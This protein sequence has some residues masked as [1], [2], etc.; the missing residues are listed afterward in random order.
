VP[1]KLRTLPSGSVIAT[2]FISLN[3]FAIAKSARV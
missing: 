2:I 3:L 1:L